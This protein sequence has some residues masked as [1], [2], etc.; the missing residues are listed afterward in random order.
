[1]LAASA[2]SRRI[3][4]MTALVATFALAVLVAATAHTHGEAQTEATSCA[5][6]SLTH[7]SAAPLPTQPSVERPSA[8]ALPSVPEASA[9][10]LPIG[11]ALPIARAPPS[12]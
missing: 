3:R 11:V 2:R 8:H 12:A 1:M 4:R 9:R 5:I 6:C 10:I 7:D